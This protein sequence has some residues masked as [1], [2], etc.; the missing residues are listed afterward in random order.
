MD[1]FRRVGP[2]VSR[3]LFARCPLVTRWVAVGAVNSVAR[4]FPVGEARGIELVPASDPGRILPPISSSTE[5]AHCYERAT[6]F[7]VILSGL[8][9]AFVSSEEHFVGGFES[10]STPPN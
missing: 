9:G 3:P 6:Y 4:E 7:T 10:I 8:V 5:H 2:P 1:F